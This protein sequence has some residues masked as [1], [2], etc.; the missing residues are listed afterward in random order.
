[1]TKLAALLLL[2]PLLYCTQ[3][4]STDSNLPQSSLYKS[5]ALSSFEVLKK[6]SL[7][8]VTYRSVDQAYKVVYIAPE[9]E[10]AYY[11]A[12]YTTETNGC[13]GCEGQERSIS[14]ELKT[15]EDTSNVVCSI[16]HACDEI[17]LESNYYKTVE[18]GCCGA[19]DELTLYDYNNKPIV[20]G[21]GKIVLGDIPN[22]G[23][24][25]W[26]GFKYSFQDS[27]LLGTVYVAYNSSE[28]YEIRI[29]QVPVPE[30]F[31]NPYAP[32]LTIRSADARDVPVE[33]RPEYE[34]WSL[35]GLDN[36]AKIDHLTLVLRF[37]CE[38]SSKG[39]APLEIPLVAGKP[40][41]KADKVQTVE[42]KM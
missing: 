7:A 11:L 14:V 10:T 18:H 5:T 39:P 2:F 32:S 1:M 17:F 30:E 37:E 16:R 21:D 38:P 12:K 20:A 9:G 4:V 23:I 42:L 29:K 19:E 33:G 40:F 28:R 35:D 27:T 25:L 34:L 3:P 41:G 31:C 13:T 15:L 6:D 22:S 36:T 26:T 24:K 8:G